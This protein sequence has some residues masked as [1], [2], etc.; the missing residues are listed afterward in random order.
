MEEAHDK[1]IEALCP[2][3]DGKLYCQR[4]QKKVQPL[5]LLLKV[6]G[7][8]VLIPL[9]QGFVP[10]QSLHLVPVV[11]SN[12]EGL[13]KRSNAVL[14]RIHIFRTRPYAITDGSLVMLRHQ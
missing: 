11:I 7:D 8:C 2:G 12:I 3:E 5:A 10:L 6:V 4:A 13:C 14:L 9:G 1:Y